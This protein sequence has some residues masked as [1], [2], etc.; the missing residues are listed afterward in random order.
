[1][2]V[3]S[4]GEYHAF[5]ARIYGFEGAVETAA[6]SVCDVDMI[7]V[8]ARSRLDSLRADLAALGVHDVDSLMT[9]RG[10]LMRSAAD[11]FGW[12]FVIER[13]TLLAGLIRRYLA[14][15]I[16]D[17]VSAAGR[18]LDDAS[19]NAGA[20]FRRFGDALG[21][22]AQAGTAPAESVAVAAVSAFRHQ[23]LWYARMGRRSPARTGDEAAPNR[24]DPTH[25]ASTA[26]AQPR[27]A[28]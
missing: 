26:P 3:T 4:V 10:I 12:L 7:H 15:R 23:H 24:H 22:F 5:L 28:A 19:R 27:D 16:P 21:T 18:Y 9:Y 20:R 1:M 14:N 13:Q 25:P 2:D 6:A 17:V 8:G 11:A